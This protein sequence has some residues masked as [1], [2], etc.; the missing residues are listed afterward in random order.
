MNPE[1]D[2]ND[3]LNQPTVTNVL[4]YD[5]KFYISAYGEMRRGGN[6]HCVK[7]W[8]KVYGTALPSTDPTQKPP[9]HPDSTAIEG[10]VVPTERDF[11]FFGSKTTYEAAKIG[12]L[13]EVAD[14]AVSTKQHLY[15]WGLSSD[16]RY[17]EPDHVEMIL[18][19]THHTNAGDTEP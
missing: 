4:D 19:V 17:A 9:Y 11:F 6:V 16:G 10:Y 5:G 15:I 14:P 1:I 13:I 18:D 2:I 3:P 7:A 8:A 12:R